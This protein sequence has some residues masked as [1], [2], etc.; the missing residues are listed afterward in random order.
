MGSEVPVIRISVRNLVEFILREG[1]IDN[2]IS[3][4]MNL[5]AMQL[6]GKIHRKIQRRM[7]TDYQA[8]VS[9]KFQI[10]LEDFVLSVEGRA[11][12]IINEPELV[13]I[14]EI[15]GT[16]SDL[17][18]L[19]E[20]VK[21]HLAQAKCYAFIYARQKGYS[22][23]GVQMTYCQMETEEIERFRYEYTI[24]ELSSWFYDVIAK[25]EKWARFQ[26]EWRKVRN[27]SMKQVQFPFEYRKGQK[28]L[29]V[30]VYKTILRKK[31]LFIQAPT[32][33]GKTISTIFPAVKAVGEELGE[34]I[35]Y[36]TAKTITRT[37]AEQA[38]QKLREQELRL[39]AITLTAKE[40]ICFCE[41]TECNPEACPYAKGH[42]D[43]V[44]DAVYELLISTDEITREVIE[45]QAELYRVCPFEMALD[46]SLWVD[47]VIC[48]YNYV[49]DP[50]VHLK[51][52]FSEGASG[53]YLFLVDEAHNLV[54]RGRKMY[55]AEI[56]KEDFLALKKLVKND[57]M[58]LYKRLEECN[59]MLLALKKECESYQILD[60]ISPIYLKLLNA[61]GEMEKYL[62]ECNKKEIRDQVLE[63]Y[64]SI[65]HFLNIYEEMDQNYEVYCEY[66]DDGRFM[67]K[68]F[69]V[70]P[71]SKLRNF[72]DMGNST[73]FFSATLLPVQYY[74]RLLSGQMDD[75]AIYAESTFDTKKRLLVNGAD[76][77][78]KYTRRT[79]D[80]YR[81]YAQYILR[82]SSVRKGNYIAFFPSY[83]FMEKV[84]D[85]FQELLVETGQEIESI[86]QSHY[87][88]EE[89]REIF[90][91]NFEEERR[92]SLIGFCVLG[93]VFS[94]GID[95]TAEK[96][97][98]AF[99]IGT[100]LPQVCNE[101]E[102]L[103]QYFDREGMQGFDYAYMY[104]GMNKV[105]QAA[106][107]V[108][109]TE[110]D[111][112]IILLLDER[113]RER[114][115]RESFPKEWSDCTVC[116]LNNIE[117]KI[118]EFWEKVEE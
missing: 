20:P 114:R 61:M 36:L 66:Q 110:E 84:Y 7:G 3:G 57:N 18:H 94:E 104:P 96:L 11:D 12:G 63:L 45:K 79:A 21:V 1:D 68:L 29:A 25:Y 38:F 97:I 60:S 76:V 89:A 73:V 5:E 107:R 83:I 47:A 100:G 115:C 108:I 67:L 52:F 48:D 31:R 40:K 95:L 116:S 32:G 74:K 56:Y 109:R 22:K 53:G 19:K 58:K 27:A 77:S 70:N 85:E 59:K 16:F 105:L 33:V 64:F 93:G 15:K 117:Q 4:G 62:E 102:I 80:M 51:R 13:V 2:R 54:E 65:R 8:E 6:G 81:R 72:L 86:L 49:F 10:S 106:G 87:M 55:S 112:G 82:A 28:E 9:L 103:K 37:V 91:E 34:K 39:K 113:F 90:L 111:K 24:D 78:T 92:E 43:R 118:V 26:I 71:A 30:S 14:D 46:V 75:Y 35:F 23:I 50:N 17:D 41:E 99:I 44:N 69:C 98:G 42:F 101:R 88:N